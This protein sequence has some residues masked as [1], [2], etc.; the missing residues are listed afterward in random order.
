MCPKPSSLVRFKSNISAVDHID[1]RTTFSL[2][3]TLQSKKSRNGCRECKRRRVKCDETYPVCQHC[4]RR[5][6]ICMQK[7]QSSKWQYESNLLV[8]YALADPLHSISHAN[9]HFR[10]WLDNTSQMLSV[11]IEPHS[12]PFALPILQHAATSKALVHACQSVSIAHEHHFDP[13]WLPICL[14][15]RQHALELVHEELRTQK[16]PLITSFLTVFILG[17]SSSWVYDSRDNFGKEH[18][19]G[20]RAILDLALADRKTRSDPLLKL[21][22]GYYLW[23][24]MSCAF[25]VHSDELRPLNTPELYSFLQEIQSQEGSH[26]FIGHCAEVLYLLGVLGRY[27]RKALDSKVYD[28]ILEDTMEQEF[29]QW[30]PVGDDPA[31]L[32]IAHGYRRHGLIIICRIRGWRL[33]DWSCDHDEMNGDFD[34][35]EN[36]QTARSHALEMIDD[37]L[38]TNPT[39]PCVNLQSIPLLTAGSELRAEDSALRDELRNRFR[40]IFSRNRVFTVLWALQLLEYVWRVND[41]GHKTSYLEI[42]TQEGWQITLV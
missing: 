28:P 14:Q 6:S 8:A 27:A 31:N 37:L 3:D 24:D 38:K 30:E 33:R 36:E 42:M 12:N 22:L 7:P 10:W 40:I 2:D 29:L 39:V 25:L 20:A 16:V 21:I 13:S 35:M 5:G 15:E 32:S 18:F 17:I 1:A 41:T 26:P 9:K 19:V 23:W 11:E 4:Q 34:L